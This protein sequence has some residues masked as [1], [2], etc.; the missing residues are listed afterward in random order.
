MTIIKCLSEKIDDE[1]H[2]ASDYVELAMKWSGEYPDVA[3]VFYE[4]STEEM[5]HMNKLHD[6]VQKEIEDYRKEHGEP[7]KEMMVLYEY[8]HAKHMETATQIRVK[9]GMYRMQAEE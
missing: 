3:E 6:A 9:Q 5:Q 4:L 8:V 7:P 2:D 1:L